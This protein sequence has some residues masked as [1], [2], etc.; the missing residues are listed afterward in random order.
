MGAFCVGEVRA[1]GRLRAVGGIAAKLFKAAQVVKS[2]GWGHGHVI[3]PSENIN[4]GGKVIEPDSREVELPRATLRMITVLAA[5]TAVDAL[6]LLFWRRNGTWAL[7]EG[8]FLIDYSHRPNQQPERPISTN[9]KKKPTSPSP[10]ACQ[11]IAASRGWPAAMAPP[12][13]ASTG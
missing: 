2:K 13:T 7:D 9:S 3:V 1:T 5:D 8:C 4:E 6:W 11:P 12:R 10:S